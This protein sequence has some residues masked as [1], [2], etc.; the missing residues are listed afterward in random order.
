MTDVRNMSELE[1]HTQEIAGDHHELEVFFGR[2]VKRDLQSF[3]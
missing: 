1:H 3:V 2:H